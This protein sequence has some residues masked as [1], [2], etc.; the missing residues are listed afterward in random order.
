[1]ANSNYSYAG[2]WALITGASAGLGVEFARRLA[3][4]GAHVILVAR[5][6]E[7]L[8]RLA[9]A[10][11]EHHGV[12]A[13]VIVSDLSQVESA[14]K[15]FEAVQRLGKEMRVL[16]NNAGFGIYGKLDETSA[17][18]NHE[19]VM[20][21]VVAMASLTRLFLPAMARARDGVIINVASTSAFQ[22]VPYMASYGASKAFVLSFTEAVWGENRGSGVRVVASCPGPVETEFFEVMGPVEPFPLRRDTVENVIGSALRAVDERRNYVIPGPLMN[23]IMANASRLAPRFW[24]TRMTARLLRR[25]LAAT[26]NAK[27]EPCGQS[28][29]T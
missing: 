13:E 1:M 5:R 7:K 15:V 4:R 26:G 19:L 9:Q 14:E 2:K 22:P 6:E 25:N 8:R 20:V 28:R 24:V 12:E 27:P 3:E 18:R 16:V 29:E 21:N 10:I 23:Y 11:R 17:E